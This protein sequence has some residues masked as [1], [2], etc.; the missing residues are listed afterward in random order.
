ML[1]DTFG[2]FLELSLPRKYRGIQKWSAAIFAETPK[3]A[4][5]EGV[6]VLTRGTNWVLKQ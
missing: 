3:P 4:E 2:S 6:R 5:T 1:Y